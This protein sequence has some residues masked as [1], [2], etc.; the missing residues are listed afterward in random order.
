MG[1]GIGA[2]GG[3]LC[4]RGEEARGDVLV[5]GAGVQLNEYER[6]LATTDLFHILGRPR[7]WS[8]VQQ[9]FLPVSPERV[10]ILEP[11]HL[12]R[13][14]HRCR[15]EQ[16]R[17]RERMQKDADDESP[18][19]QNGHRRHAAENGIS[20]EKLGLILWLTN[21][22]TQYYAAPEWWEEWAY[23]MTFRE[24]LATTGSFRHAAMPQQYQ[25]DAKTY[26]T[27]TIKTVNAWVDWWLVLIPSGTEDWGTINGLPVHAMVTYV[28]AGLPKD[29]PGD[30][31]RVEGWVEW[32]IGSFAGD[33]PNAFVELSKMD[34]VSAARRMNQHI[35]PLV[36]RFENRE[37]G[38]QS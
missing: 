6:I 15:D 20:S 3:G 10:L 33:S 24:A 36:W 32:S 12:D 14:T 17:I 34:C 31:L 5:H 26:A 37:A 4:H 28:L 18:S 8:V 38:K 35:V 25:Y 11:K 22:L 1:V 13:L 21:E 19:C 27:T 23:N 9:E 2:A 16:C 29:G 30:R 7:S